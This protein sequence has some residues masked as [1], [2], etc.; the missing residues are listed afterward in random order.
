MYGEGGAASVTGVGGGGARC[1]VTF[2]TDFLFACTAQGRPGGT[3]GGSIATRGAPG[4]SGESGSGG[5]LEVTLSGS[6]ELKNST[7]AWNKA[8][9]G[10]G[11]QGRPGLGSARERPVQLLTRRGSLRLL[12]SP[13]EASV[14]RRTRP[15]STTLRTSVRMFTA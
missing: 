6:V 14:S 9:G 4:G 15:L 12:T 5:G 10:N 3:G 7:I 11:G 2:D 1:D 8:V 13:A